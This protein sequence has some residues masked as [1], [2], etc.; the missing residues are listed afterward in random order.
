M[1]APRLM[2][3]HWRINGTIEEVADVLGDVE[4]LPNWWGDVYL[5][6][7][8]IDPG[9]EDGIGRRIAFHSRG[10][11]PYTLRWQGEV[12]AADRPHSWTIAATGDLRGRG[13]WR[14][15]QD[16]EIADV[17]YDWQVDV[18]KPLLRALAPV[19]WPV[20]AANHRWAMKKGEEGLR[21]ELARR[22]E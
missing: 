11:L 15:R 6:V 1:A 18:D 3:S 22:R 20:F 10:I 2:T 16:D 8:V 12:V 17:R 14:L 9:G 21:A 13:V 5:G 19:L 4:R 7:A